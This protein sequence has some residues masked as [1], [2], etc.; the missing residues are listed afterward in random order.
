VVG[1]RLVLANLEISTNN[2]IVRKARYIQTGIS[3]HS[4]GVIASE[5][6][7]QGLCKSP[8]ELQITVIHF[9]R[10][11]YLNQNSDP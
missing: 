8:A 4:A 10:N 1:K 11:R 7:G 2:I 9:W 3:N 5:I 6:K